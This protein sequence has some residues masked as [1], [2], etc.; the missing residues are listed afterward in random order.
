MATG[1]SSWHLRSGVIALQHWL[2][3]AEQPLIVWT[4]HRNLKYIKSVKRLSSHQTCFS[5]F[6]T[7]FNF[8]LAYRPAV[9]GE[10]SVSDPT[11]I[12]DS[13]HLVAA[14]TQPTEDRI[15]TA[16]ENQPGPSH[17]L[18]GNRQGCAGSSSASLIPVPA[19]VLS[20]CTCA[21]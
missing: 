18:L 13:T 3:G 5:L 8:T 16:M 2:K 15:R 17:A 1:W 12:L 19:Q 11:P 4:D 10:R 20:F 7:R 9:P 14:V 21:G 6:L